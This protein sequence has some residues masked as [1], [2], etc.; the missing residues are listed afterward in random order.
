MKG[1]RERE[2][3][4]TRSCLEEVG[5][6]SDTSEQGKES[7]GHDRKSGRGQAGIVTI[8]IRGG[9]RGGRRGSGG[10]GS[11]GREDGRR[12]ACTSGRGWGGW[13]ESGGRIIRVGIGERG[14]EA[15][16]A[17]TAFGAVVRVTEALSTGRWTQKKSQV[18]V[19]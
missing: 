13:D 7:I 3:R 8:S 4:I 19:R 11:C 10:C 9:S 6:H 1:G 5:E 2:N 15:G 18:L 14:W 12:W 16:R 17:D